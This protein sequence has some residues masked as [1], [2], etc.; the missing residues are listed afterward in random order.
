MAANG[1]LEVFGTLL[2]CTRVTYLIDAL[3]ESRLRERESN[4]ESGWQPP[5]MAYKHTHTISFNGT[6]KCSSSVEGFAQRGV[7]HRK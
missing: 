1:R 4:R 7:S 3:T 2:L 5:N 6:V